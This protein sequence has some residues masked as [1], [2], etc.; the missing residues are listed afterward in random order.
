MKGYRDN[1]AGG[2]GY[3]ARS[4]TVY[5]DVFGGPPKF[6]ATTL[7]PRLED[8]TEIFQGFHASRGSSIPVLDL[9]PPCVDSDDVWFDVR[10]SKLDYSEV[11][12]GFNGL[13]FALSYEELFD[14][15]KVEEDDDSSDDVW[16]PAQSESL[17]DESDPQAS[18]E[19]NQQVPNADLNQ[20]SGVKLKSEPDF[21]AEK[22][23]LNGTTNDSQ[24]LEVSGSTVLNNQALPSKKEN[25]KFFSLANNDL[26]TNKDLGGVA[27]GKK[28]KKSLSQSTTEIHNRPLLSVSDLSL[29]TQPSNLP[30]PSRPPPALTSKKG[31]SSNFSPK[32][33]T[34]KSY[35]FERTTTDQSPPFF[36]VEIDASSSAA[37]D[38]AAMK[39]AVEQAQAKLRSAK[40]AMDRKKEGLQSRSKMKYN[41]GDKKVKVNQNYEKSHSFQGERTRRLFEND[42]GITGSKKNNNI[43][44]E[45][46]EQKEDSEIVQETKEGFLREHTAVPKTPNDSDEN[47]MYE[48]LIEI[49]LKDNDILTVEKIVTENWLKND[50]NGRKGDDMGSASNAWVDYDVESE[51]ATEKNKEELKENEE[52][53]EKEFQQSGPPE[54]MLIHSEEEDSERIVKESDNISQ[55]VSETVNDC[56]E[57]EK[58]ETMHEVDCDLEENRKLQKESVSENESIENERMDIKWDEDEQMD[59]KW[60]DNE[61]LQDKED[62]QQDAPSVKHEVTPETPCSEKIKEPVEQLHEVDEESFSNKNDFAGVKVEVRPADVIKG[63]RELENERLRKI[64]E[65]NERE[66]ERL[67]IIEEENERENERLRKIE[68][69]NE[70]EKERLRKIE[71]ENERENERLR[72]IEEENERENERLRKIEEENEREKERL[73]KIEEEN[74]REKERL[75]KIEE[76]REKE[77]FRK[78]DRELENERVR[79][80]EEEREIEKE[81]LRKIERE[82]EDER[83]RKIEEERERQIEREKDRMA[84]DRATLEAREKTFAETRERAA[85]ERATAEF[86]QRA[87]AEARERLEKACAEAR[88]R[89]LADKAMEGRLRVEKATAEARE[90][91]VADK[92]SIRQNSLPS[93]LAGSYSGLR[94]YQAP[95]QGGEGESPQ[96]CKARLERH[97]RT[98]DRAAKALAEKNMR[99]LI[100]QKEQ[101]ERS[102]LAEGLDA[103]VK[104]WSS[105]KQGNLRALL[106][107]LQYILGP[108]S[109]WQPV[110]LTEVITTAAVKKAYRKATLCVHPDKLQQ[111]GATIQQKY[112][113]EKVFDLLKEAWNKFN[114]EER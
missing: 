46:F 3:G 67:R 100:A 87:L 64:E 99:D 12:G 84:V 108:D 52:Q 102:R 57:N 45:Y 110:P 7:P 29:K 18:L 109:G 22:D 44:F 74:E 92:F 80:L 38:A 93:D 21:E 15:S 88:E 83:L 28:L 32:L 41:I 73:R 31:D 26:C 34:S 35:A 68:E 14:S 8:Y 77:R 60:D 30:P 112:I 81:R 70:R 40:A 65:E 85:V 56:G 90:R 13:D 16:T 107:T 48:N 98:A 51:E 39:D 10:S 86:R 50:I 75:R 43:V 59:I 1:G 55:T 23:F 71:E 89:S 20:S 96:R 53:D 27:E 47:E 62:V 95:S 5:D 103:E 105:G 63:A 24:C 58:A 49:Q 106:S 111:R 25:E 97:Q 76:E 2:G 79:K 114:S 37:A 61:I 9:P 94:Y 4:T 42:S 11:F 113:C 104:R 17:S 19:M 91:A 6:G 36:D 82:Q 33:K 78:I 72:K 69:E 66:N 54:I 101:A